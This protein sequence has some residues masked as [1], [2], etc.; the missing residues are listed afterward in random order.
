MTIREAYHSQRPTHGRHFPAFGTALALVSIRRNLRCLRTRHPNDPDDGANGG[1]FRSGG[2]GDG[3]GEGAGVLAFAAATLSFKI[4]ATLVPR[5]RR[6][7]QHLKL[8]QC[9]SHF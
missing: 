2:A 8:S 6:L 1:H 3:A 5:R 7:N 9:R 4:G